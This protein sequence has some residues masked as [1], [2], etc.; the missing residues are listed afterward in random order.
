MGKIWTIAKKELHA[1]F[2][3]PIAYIAI[4]IYLILVGVTFFFKIPFL[5]PKENFFEAREATLRPLFQWSV[6]LMAV[7]LPAISMRLF[8]EEKKDG[9]LELLMTM[10]VS[11]FQV[12]MGKFVG[13]L[14][15]L[16]VA[17]GL[18]VGYVILVFALGKPDIGPLLGGYF[19]VFLMGGGFLAIGLMASA[20]TKSQIVA[21]V[22]A[23][24]I[25][26]FLLFADRIP[27]LF[28]LG[29]VQLFNLLSFNYHFESITRGVI[30]S[31]DIV[32]F[33]SVMALA[34]EITRYTL[35]SRKWR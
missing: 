29:G 1:Y 30:D 34:L 5:F 3:S 27:E 4:S 28:G 21:F 22:V 2:S 13:A 35:E 18:T 33:L 16:A 20:W 9:T 12:V 8:A 25:S 7:L 10:P 11:D 19:G 26:G 6:V 14:A 32:Y 15:F 17:L 23:L 24:V 31:R